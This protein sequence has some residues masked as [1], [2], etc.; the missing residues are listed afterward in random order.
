[1]RIL[2]HDPIIGK[3]LDS[4]DKL[5]DHIKNRYLFGSRVRDDWRPD[6]FSICGKYHDRGDPDWRKKTEELI[7]EYIRKAE[8]K[9]KA[10]NNLFKTGDYEDWE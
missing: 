10:S 4:T 7:R 3:W 9:I 1:M 8:K 6:S 2:L 5:R